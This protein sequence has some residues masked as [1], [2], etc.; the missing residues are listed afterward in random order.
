MNRTLRPHRPSPD[1]LRRPGIP[2]QINKDG[3][4]F[5]PAQVVH[6]STG[7]DSTEAPRLG[8]GQRRARDIGG[9]GKEAA[10]SRSARTTLKGGV[11]HG[12]GV[13]Q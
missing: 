12:K 4:A 7:L 8:G 6:I 1:R 11:S 9:R 10:G 5:Q 3:S 13:I 2:I